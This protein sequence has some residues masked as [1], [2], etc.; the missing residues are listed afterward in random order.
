ML[1]PCER[2]SSTALVRLVKVCE[3][4]LLWVFR[5]HEGEQP[6]Q[7]KGHG[8]LIHVS[9]F[10]CSQTGQL[11]ILNKD[12]EIICSACKII[13]PG[14]NGDPWW[15]NDQ[16]MVQVKNAIEIFETSHPGCQVVFIFD[17]SWAHT[18][19]LPD[20]LHA[21]EMNKSDGGRQWKQCNT[22]ISMTSPDP[23]FRGIHRKWQQC[24][25]R[26]KV[27]RLSWR[28]V[29][30]ISKG[31]RPNV[32]WFAPSKAR[33]AAWHGFCHNRMF[34]LIK[35]PC[36]RLLSKK[37]AT[38]ACFYQSFFAN[39]ILLRWWVFVCYFIPFS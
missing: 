27:W 26:Q 18:S 7:K 5:L 36:S 24:Q 4:N 21:L 17:Q 12:G 32:P 38:S 22:I 6:L 2:W 37:L 30:L 1:F 20:A 33:S 8:W 11:V 34:L 10:I 28:S 9:D 29:G 19:L 15:D 31:L 35:N 39:L 16:L 25:V 23:R 14:V 3:P 13:F